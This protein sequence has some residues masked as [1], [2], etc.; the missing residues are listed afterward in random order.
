MERNKERERRAGEFLKE[1]E[2][3]TVYKGQC[4]E[5]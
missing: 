1:E 2:W 5:C 3:R 4:M